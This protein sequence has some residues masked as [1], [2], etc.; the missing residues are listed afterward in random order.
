[1]YPFESSDCPT[2]VEKGLLEVNQRANHEFL[3]A[4]S[5]DKP[6]AKPEHKPNLLE[7]IA[8]AKNRFFEKLAGIP[9]VR[10]SE[11]HTAQIHTSMEYAVLVDKTTG[12]LCTFFYRETDD[13]DKKMKGE[14]VE[15]ARS[16]GGGATFALVSSEEGKDFIKACALMDKL[17]AFAIADK[18]FPYIHLYMSRK[19]TT[20]FKE[21]IDRYERGELKLED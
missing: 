16:L 8:A 2:D 18:K 11:D 21:L 14:M 4:D 7:R 15:L 20:S 10:V 6:A 13:N 1:M 19:D 5:L 3:L 9:D 17:P 12:P